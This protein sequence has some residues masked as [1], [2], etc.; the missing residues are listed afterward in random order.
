MK[1]ERPNKQEIS[2]LVTLRMKLWEDIVSRLIGCVTY[3]DACITIIDL[4]HKPVIFSG[5]RY[6]EKPRQWSSGSNSSYN[7]NQYKYD[8]DQRY[9][10]SFKDEPEESPKTY[11]CN[12]Y[13]VTIC[14]LPN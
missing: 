12:I 13:Y 14:I 6:S 4:I 7:K 5:D 3:N 10:K 8:E 2:L 1:G 9:G 11:V